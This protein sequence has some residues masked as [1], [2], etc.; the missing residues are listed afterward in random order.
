VNRWLAYVACW[1]AFGAD[2]SSYDYISWNIG[3]AASNQAPLLV[4]GPP[5]P[6]R[7][8]EPISS[9]LHNGSEELLY[10]TP[11][12]FLPRLLPIESQTSIEK[13]P[14]SARHRSLYS[15]GY[16]TLRLPCLVSR[17]PTLLTFFHCSIPLRR[18]LTLVLA[19][20]CH[21]AFFHAPRH[22]VISGSHAG[23]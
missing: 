23:C 14:F 3:C 17:L 15:S 21:H 18:L 1:G 6:G 4:P 8:N 19:T 2:D 11:F 12:P 5:A 10:I 20:R 16:A 7:R 22:G 13:R 9:G